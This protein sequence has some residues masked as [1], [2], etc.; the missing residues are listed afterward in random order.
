MTRHFSLAGLLRLRQLREDQAAGSLAQA[1]ERLRDSRAR[2]EAVAESL[3]GTD[4]SPS[5]SASLYAV[6]AARASVRSMLVDLQALEAT[7]QSEQGRAQDQYRAARV[8]TMG[9]EKLEERHRD[10]ET[11]AVIGAE[12]RVLDELATTG[13]RR[14][15]S[16]VRP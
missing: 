14:T 5:G 16:E 11:A 4:L 13:R 10:T 15:G 9:L 8:A 12:Q 2:S 1:N 6:A 3:D 7:L